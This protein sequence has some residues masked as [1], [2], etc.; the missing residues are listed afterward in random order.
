VVIK[1]SI[2]GFAVLTIALV[3]PSKADNSTLSSKLQQ[4]CAPA[5]R[6]AQQAAVANG[7]PCD[8]FRDPNCRALAVQKGILDSKCAFPN[9]QAPIRIPK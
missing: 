6:S 9:I 4:T 5:L 2:A 8:I 3:S 7:V 1:C